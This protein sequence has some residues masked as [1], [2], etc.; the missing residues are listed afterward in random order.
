M[1]EGY[2]T[3]GF[4]SEEA[5]TVTV[6]VLYEDVQTSYT[7]EVLDYI[8]GDIDG[9]LTVNKEDVMQLLWHVSFPE[10]YPIIIPADYTGDNVVDKEDVMQLLWHVSFPEMYPLN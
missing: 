2:T 3:Q 7:V 1:T 8:P 9:N 10:M 5:G 4:T 6:T